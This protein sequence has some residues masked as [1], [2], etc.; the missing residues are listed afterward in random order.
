MLVE[1]AD[2][3]PR[4]TF[5]S[6][7]GQAVL[8]DVSV[9]IASEVLQEG[10]RWGA[11]AASEL[12]ELDDDDV[13]HA[14]SPAFAK[15]EELV[16]L[17]PRERMGIAFGK[18]AAAVTALIAH[19]ADGTRHI[20]AAERSAWNG[21]A[22]AAHAHVSDTTRHITSA[23]RGAW[24]AAHAAAN[25]AMPRAGG[26]FTGNVLAAGT[27]RAGASLRNSEVYHAGMGAHAATD[28]LIFVRK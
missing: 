9:E 1:E 25:A 5:R 3:R 11:L 12:L 4:L 7:T 27:N 14:V 24:N 19:L 18:L 16:E 21:A 28:R 10:D 2:G 22:D 15:T 8:E 26:Q 17:A 6:R 23:E 13:P 20:T